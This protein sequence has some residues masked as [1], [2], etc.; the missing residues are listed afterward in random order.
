[1][2]NGGW[3]MVDEKKAT[4]GTLAGALQTTPLVVPP[5]GGLAAGNRRI[6]NKEF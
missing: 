4:G 1:M 5:Q 3:L 6:V 2:V